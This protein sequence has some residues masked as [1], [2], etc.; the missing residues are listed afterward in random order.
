MVKKLRQ[1]TVVATINR[2]LRT[3]FIVAPLH[4]LAHVCFRIGQRLSISNTDIAAQKT[5]V[6]NESACDRPVLSGPGGMLVE[7]WRERQ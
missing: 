4:S 6:A 3:S 2:Q 7:S 5:C 1:S